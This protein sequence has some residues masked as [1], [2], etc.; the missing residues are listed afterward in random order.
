MTGTLE[1]SAGHFR[2]SCLDTVTEGHLNHL[3]F[4]TDV[5]EEA[6]LSSVWVTQCFSLLFLFSFGQVVLGPDSSSLY[7]Y[8]Y[9]TSIENF[10]YKFACARMYASVRIDTVL[11]GFLHG[12]PPYA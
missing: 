5:T 8:H 4:F 11:G 3:S 12:S 6:W 9:L 1:A 10:F 2:R 7:C